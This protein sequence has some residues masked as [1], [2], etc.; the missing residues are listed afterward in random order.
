MVESSM[1]GRHTRCLNTHGNSHMSH[2]KFSNLIVIFTS[3]SAHAHTLGLTHTRTRTHHL[4]HDFHH[5]NFLSVILCINSRNS[6]IAVLPMISRASTLIVNLLLRFSNDFQFDY[7]YF[8]AL[9]RTFVHQIVMQ[10]RM[11]ENHKYT[12]KCSLTSRFDCF[13]WL[14]RNHIADLLFCGYESTLK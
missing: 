6:N 4:F 11:K 12:T 9:H 1:G 14:I 3:T 2:R 7:I 8:G 5:S 10:Q 13:L